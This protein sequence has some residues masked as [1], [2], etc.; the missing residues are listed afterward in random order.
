MRS[1]WSVL[2]CVL[3][4]LL[5]FSS[6]LISKVAFVLT[7][8][9]PVAAQTIVV[10]DPPNSVSTSPRSINDDGWIAGSFLDGLTGTGRGFIRTPDGQFTVFDVE[11]GSPGVNVRDI[12][13]NGAVL[14]WND[15]PSGDGQR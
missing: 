8:A 11:P 15:P 4:K 9:A 14:G 12:N 3:T 6:S 5:S 10:F 13:A 1:T 2:C 7:L